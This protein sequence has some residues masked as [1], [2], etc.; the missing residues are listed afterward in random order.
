MTEGDDFDP[1]Q[2]VPDRIDII[3]ADGIEQVHDHLSD[4]NAVEYA[5][6]SVEEQAT[7]LWEMVD[8]GVIDLEI[9]GR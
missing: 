9:S 5:E 4:E 6:A 3:T 8:R 1:H 2:Y 7:F